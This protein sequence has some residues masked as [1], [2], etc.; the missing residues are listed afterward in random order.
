KIES[1]SGRES[2]SDSDHGSKSGSCSS[3]SNSAESASGSESGSDSESGSSASASGSDSGSGKSHEEDVLSKCGGNLNK[4]FH[5]T[6]VTKAKHKS[7]SNRE[8]DEHPDVFGIRRSARS[9]KEPDRLSSSVVPENENDYS[10]TLR[11]TV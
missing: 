8:W 11:H 1:Q 6:T 3:R 4:S 5:N 7:E 10:K 2:A 9:R